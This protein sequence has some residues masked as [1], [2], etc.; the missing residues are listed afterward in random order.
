MRAWEA[1]LHERS[2][3]RLLRSSFKGDLVAELLYRVIV[4]RPAS[5]AERDELRRKA[6]G[7]AELMDL[8]HEMKATEEG[9]RVVI[10]GV[11]PALRTYLRAQFDAATG[12]SEQPR[13]VFLHFMK[14]GG[15]TIS[16]TFTGWFPSERTR[17]HLFLDDIALA[18]PQMLANLRIIAGHIPFNAL[19]LIPGPY[20]TMTLLR[21]PFS[22]TISHFT[23]LKEVNPQYRDLT[24][25]RFVLDEEMDALSGN[26]QARQLAFDMRV[27]SA[28]RDHNPEHVV[29]VR[30]A[31]P[32]ATPLPLSSLFDSVPMDL[33]GEELLAKASAN[34]EKIDIVGV[35]DHLQAAVWK[36]AELFGRDPEPV[37][38]LNASKP[39]ARP[40]I[41]SR[42][43]REIARRT[44]ID[45]E[46]YEQA[47]RRSISS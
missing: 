26:Y 21:D 11:P 12:E 1:D 41:D 16:D 40:D 43:S 5:R 44:E 38:R 23:H 46:L 42:L 3:E 39:E 2:F 35:T 33:A 13:L 20:Q 30:G 31:D 25:E 24:L 7:G 6:R 15:T 28:W 9:A 29:A 47:K 22:R 45:Q 27:A 18:P 34:L 17:V 19:A 14:V 37:G 32:L 10:H 36:A 8:A 4:G